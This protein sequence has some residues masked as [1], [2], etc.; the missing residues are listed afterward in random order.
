MEENN[1][2]HMIESRRVS[3]TFWRKLDHYFIVVFVLLTPLLATYDLVQF[4]FFDSYDGESTPK[5]L[6]FNYLW[7]IPAILL[8]IVQWRRLKLQEYK[9]TANE[10]Q[11]QEALIQTSQ[12]L[13]WRIKES[14]PEFIR[15]FRGWNLTAS[16][17][18]MITIIPFQDSILI[19]SICDPNKPSSIASFGM[20]KTNTRTFIINLYNIVNGTSILKPEEKYNKWSFRNNLFRLFA[21]PFCLGL[22]LFA[23]FVALPDNQI[24][25]GVAILTVPAIYFYTDL[26]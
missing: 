20:N 23:V 9:I 12:E 15:A 10:D 21:Y 19:N 3:L 4:Y 6:L 22:I 8:T 1:V 18:E 7:L 25:L 2:K 24:G 17:G 16:L 26:T 13:G 11:I 14:S 5:E